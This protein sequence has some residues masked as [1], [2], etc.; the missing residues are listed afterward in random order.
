M[1]EEDYIYLKEKK[2]FIKAIK[3]GSRIDNIDYSE[4]DKSLRKG[5]VEI[6]EEGVLTCN[7][8]STNGFRGVALRIGDRNVPEPIAVYFEYKSNIDNNLKVKTINKA[9][10]TINEIY[11]PASSNWKKRLLFMQTYNN[12]PLKNIALEI[13]IGAT[14]PVAEY[15]IRNV[16]I[17][18][19]ITKKEAQNSIDKYIDFNHITEITST[20]PFIKKFLIKKIII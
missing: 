7:P 13:G 5:I 10:T 6:S 1:I 20:V 12:V 8:V 18:Y 19:K 9:N 2:D 3:N 4:M 15:S 14:Y 16:I 17:Y 11:L